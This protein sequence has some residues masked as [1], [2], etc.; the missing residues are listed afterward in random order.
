MKVIVIPRVRSTSGIFYF[1]QIQV[2]FIN[3][4]R[5]LVVFPFNTTSTK[6]ILHGFQKIWILSSSGKKISRVERSETREMFGHE[7]IKSIAFGNRV[8]SFMYFL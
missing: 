6:K 4:S 3:S 7:K 5:T 1:H 2:V 8:I